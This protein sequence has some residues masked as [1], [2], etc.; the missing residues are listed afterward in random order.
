LKPS[1]RRLTRFGMVFVAR[2]KVGQARFGVRKSPY[3]G[4]ISHG[5]HIQETAL[6]AR[7]RPA[8]DFCQDS[9]A[10]DLGELLNKGRRTLPRV[11]RALSV[12]EH[13]QRPTPRAPRRAEPCPCLLL[14]PAP[15]KPTKASTVLP[16]VLST[17]PEHQITGIAPRTACPRP[18]D[19][20]PP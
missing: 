1:P 19:P 16:R 8:P 12:P 13:A 7:R 15:I 2:W 18:P 14:A 11:R 6:G 9:H 20:P 17:S 4:H 3:L 10:C 5:T